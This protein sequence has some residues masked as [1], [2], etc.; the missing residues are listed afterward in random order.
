MHDAGTVDSEYASTN[1]VFETAWDLHVS[2]RGLC[3]RRLGTCG[4]LKPKRLHTLHT[5]PTRL[6]C[7]ACPKG[8][9]ELKQTLSSD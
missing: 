5:P 2:L 7:Q 1:Q 6:C 4:A 9:E 8:R 3:Q